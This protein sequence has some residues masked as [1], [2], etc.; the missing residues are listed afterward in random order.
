MNNNKNHL[1]DF[2]SPIE[3]RFAYCNGEPGLSI[4]SEDEKVTLRLP[5]SCPE[6]G[7]LF[8]GDFYP[9]QPFNSL[10]S[11][12]ND[13]AR[14][15]SGSE[16]E[17]SI[18]EIG[19]DQLNPH[20]QII[21]ETAHSVYNF[22]VVDPQLLQGRL[23]GGILGNQIACATLKFSC[24][25]DENPLFTAKRLKSGLSLVF[26][27]EWGNSFRQL[28]TSTITRLLLRSDHAN[29][30]A[31]LSEKR[32]SNSAFITLRMNEIEGQE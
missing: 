2:N 26:N 21:I 19:L 15:A 23:I 5:P 31:A 20:D 7:D 25:A 32:L 8:E 11:Q 24:S 12:L 1:K 30:P 16:L 22:T 13:Q 17:N 29:R 9:Y 28:I 18:N 3:H 14:Q 4:I 6:A 27:I 10:V